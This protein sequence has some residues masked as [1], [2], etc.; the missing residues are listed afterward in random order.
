MDDAAFFDF[1]GGVHA[2][3]IFA[4]NNDEAADGRADGQGLPMVLGDLGGAQ[5]P[6]KTGKSQLDLVLDPDFGVYADG[7]ENGLVWIGLD[8]LGPYAGTL[9]PA[10]TLPKGMG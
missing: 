4:A 2:T 9:D 8:P 1:R 10:V 7:R 5:G 6:G 3:D